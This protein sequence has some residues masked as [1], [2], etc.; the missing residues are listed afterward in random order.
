MKPKNT[1]LLIDNEVNHCQSLQTK[2]SRQ[3]IKINYFHNF[4]EGLKELEENFEIYHGIILD[5]Y[6]FGDEKAQ[7]ENVESEDYIFGMKDKL[8]DIFKQKQTTIPFC[9]NTGFSSLQSKLEH[10]GI[11]VFGKNDDNRVLEY[12]VEEYEDLDSTKVQRQYPEAFEVFE[13]TGFLTVDRK[14]DLINLLLEAQNT[15]SIIQNIGLTRQFLEDM[16]ENLQEIEQIPNDLVTTYNKVNINHCIRYLC[17]EAI[18]DKYPPRDVDFPSHIKSCLYMIY[19]MTNSVGNHS[20]NHRNLVTR[21]TF[22]PVL[23]ALIEVL[24]WYNYTMKQGTSRTQNQ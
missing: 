23:F 3:N 20:Y 24:N 7:E 19:Y 14:H 17:G 10:S 8:K 1:F 21:N 22:R 15:T 6:C 11:K 12:L 9:V 2:A 18:D 13:G 5:A 16:F 4:A